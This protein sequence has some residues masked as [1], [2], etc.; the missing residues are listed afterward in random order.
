MIDVLRTL[1]QYPE[2]RDLPSA[3]GL[4]TTS[5]ASPSRAFGLGSGSPATLLAA[6]IIGQ[7]GITISTP[8]Q[9][10]GLL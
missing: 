7:I 9:G 4:G 3:L 2:I 5:A 1:R 10:T 8:P 6:V